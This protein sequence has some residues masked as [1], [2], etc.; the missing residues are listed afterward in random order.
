MKSSRVAC[1]V[2]SPPVIRLNLT[3]DVVILTNSVHLNSFIFLIFFNKWSSG[4]TVTATQIFKSV[5]VRKQYYSSIKRR[6]DELKKVEELLRSFGAI[7]PNVRLSLYHNKSN[8]WQKNKVANHKVALINMWGS[9][10]MSQM[11]HVQRLVDEDGNGQVSLIFSRC[12]V[13][14]I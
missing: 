2:T 11:Q 12:T 13:W 3:N 5:P 1:H 14:D 9:S 10:V 4:T 6:R 8:I 7:C